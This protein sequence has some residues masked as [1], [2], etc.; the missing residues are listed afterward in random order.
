MFIKGNIVGLRAMEP[1][2]SDLIYQWENDMELWKSGDTLTPYSKF[3]IDQFVINAS[4]DIYEA[5]QLR[6]MIELLEESITVGAIDLYDFDPYHLRA[7][8]GIMINRAYRQKGYASE[9]LGLL[10]NYAFHTLR[11]HQL[12]CSIREDNYESISLF[13]KKNFQISGTKAEWLWDGSSWKGELFM[14]LIQTK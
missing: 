14:Q 5:K 2:D 11:L 12:F 8:V 4:K 9:A 7:G 1:K 13:R 3:S 6:L 10:I